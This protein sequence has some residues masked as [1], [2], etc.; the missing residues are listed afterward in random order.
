MTDCVFCKII[1]R[2]IPSSIIKEN[3]HVIVFRDLHP[4]APIHYLIA[5][6][7]HIENLNFLEDTDE[8]YNMIKEMFKMIKLLAKDLPD[9]K[10]F[11]LVSN[12]GKNAGQSVFHMH[13]HFL[14]G[15]V[16]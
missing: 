14:S 8:H 4:Q 1:K 15:S 5:P 3:D 12:N 6:K 9:Q 13:W 7:I 2:E 16:R 10:A 11:T